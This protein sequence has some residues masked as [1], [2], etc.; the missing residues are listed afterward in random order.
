LRAQGE[1]KRI[2]E[3]DPFHQEARSLRD[4]LSSDTL[5]N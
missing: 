2:L 4:Q 1:L 5:K 3:R